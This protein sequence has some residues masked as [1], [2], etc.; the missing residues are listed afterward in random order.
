MAKVIPL[1]TIKQIIEGADD[2]MKAYLAFHY[3]S[4]SRMGELIYYKNSNGRITPGLD[5]SKIDV[6]EDAIEWEQPNFKAPR[7]PTKKAFVLRKEKWLYDIIKGWL[8]ICDRKVFPYKISWTKYKVNSYLRQFGF[9]SHDLR[10]SRGTHLSEKFGY[11]VFDINRILGHS[12]LETSLAY[13]HPTEMK[14]KLEKVLDE[15]EKI[16]NKEEFE[17]E[18]II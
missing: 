13:V 17:K 12:R 2:W 8:K 3:V 18:E 10:H 16:E 9:S 6:R 5:K 11:N 14:E 7:K 15:E 4:A 1:G